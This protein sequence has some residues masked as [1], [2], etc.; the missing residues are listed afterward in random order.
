MAK[1]IFFSWQSDL[2]TRTHRNLIE[3]C[4]NRA[5]KELGKDN[6]TSIYMEYDRD[7]KNMS[8]S[9]DISATIFDK[10]E[11]SVLFICDISIINKDYIG[12]KTP[13]PN[14]L[15]E[16]GFAIKCLGWDRVICVFDEATGKIGDLP[17]DLRQK[18]VLSYNSNN[19]NEKARIVSILKDNIKSLFIAGKLFNPLNDYMKARID[20]TFLDVCKQL[21]NILLGTITMSEGLR[22]TKSFLNFTKVQIIDRLNHSEFPAF[23]FLNTY[24]T[25]SGELREIL[26]ELLSS[27]YFERE[28]SYTVLNYIDWLR[29]YKH[30]TSERNPNTII[31]YITEKNIDGYAVI[32]GTAI[33]SSNPV[34]SKIVLETFLEKG[35]E[36]IDSTRGK[37]INITQYPSDNPRKLGR[38]CRFNKESI[39]IVANILYEFQVLCKQWLDITDSEFILD[40]DYYIID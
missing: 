25:V 8:G 34:N 10:I 17:F 18:R 33:N 22:N 15:I 1:T 4:I 39:E 9:P 14:V 24:D 38:K 36:Y 7:T 35:Q 26:K 5:L 37:V 23:L 40:P 6:Q 16:L 3:T 30:L 2:E 19:D 32:S 31:E 20:K 27:T 13:N 29:Q 28:W 21:S 11:K 12:K